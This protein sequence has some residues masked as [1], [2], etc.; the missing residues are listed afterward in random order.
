MEEIVFIFRRGE[1]NLPTHPKLSFKFEELMNKG[2]SMG[3]IAEL[4]RQDAAITSK[5][6]AVSNS[7]VYRGI[8]NNKTLEQAMGRLGLNTTKQYVE[9]IQNRTLYM[10]MQKAYVEIIEKLWEHALSC[11]YAC[12]ITAQRLHLTLTEDAFTLGL[13]HDLG[14]LVILQTVGKLQE[15]KKLGEN[16]DES[17]VFATMD[18]YHG[19]FGA[20]LL[21]LWKF[22]E[23]FSH[24]AAYHDDLSDADP[25]SKGLLVVHFSNLLVKSMGYGLSGFDADELM[26]AQSTNLL[27]LT[28]DDI[29]FISDNVKPLMEEFG[30]FFS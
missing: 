16:I 19:K 20:S 26:D 5:L 27:K 6:I 9:V 29:R 11:A 15:N 25:I 14:R 22:S 4:L 21:K 30:T 12:Q 10:S 2:A 3:T 17:E 28:K 18:S 8:S 1:I 24:I 23:D 13:L 7:P